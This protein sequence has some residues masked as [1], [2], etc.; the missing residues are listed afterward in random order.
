MTLALL[1]ARG[2]PRPVRSIVRATLIAILAC[3]WPLCAG[4]AIITMRYDGTADLSGFGGSPTATFEGSVTWDSTIGPAGGIFSETARYLFDG[5]DPV[6][7]RFAIDGI[8]YTPRIRPGSRFEQT[9]SE[10]FLQLL[11]DPLI[12]LD[13]GQATDIDWVTLDLWS[14]VPVF[15]DIDTLPD[16]LTFLTQLRHRRFWFVGSDFFVVPAT[17]LD[18]PEPGAAALLLLALCGAATRARRRRS[19]RAA[20]V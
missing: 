6:S 10:L 14:D 18:V 2:R 16:D 13:G 17:T 12:D 3:T 7:A 19:N 11:F 20:R 4:A 15:D 9:D 8:D 1:L 5:E